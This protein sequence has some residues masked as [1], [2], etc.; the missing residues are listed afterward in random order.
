M[1]IRTVHELASIVREQR[2]RLN[3][4]QEDLA[5][6]SGVGRQWVNEFENGKPG[7]QIVHV[8]RVLNA[9]EIPLNVDLP[10]SEKKFDAP[11]DLDDLVDGH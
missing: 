9:L 7:A 10:T 2:K 3:W 5:T 11:F 1:F 8:L 6:R 4:S